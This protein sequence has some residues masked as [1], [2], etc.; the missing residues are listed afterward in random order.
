MS[1]VPAT[2]WLESVM[3]IAIRARLS[4]LDR[5][6]DDAWEAQRMLSDARDLFALIRTTEARHVTKGL[7]DRGFPFESAQGELGALRREFA[8][9]VRALARAWSYEGLEQRNLRDM[10]YLAETTPLSTLEDLD[11]IR[12][13]RLRRL[14]AAC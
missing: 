8:A 14:A 9:L 1:G 3:P 11:A 5:T 6:P 12:S 7:R 10:A 13:T 4:Q 2:L